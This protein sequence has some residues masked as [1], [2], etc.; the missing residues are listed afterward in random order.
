LRYRELLTYNKKC[1]EKSIKKYLLKYNNPFGGIRHSTNNDINREVTIDDL[2][3]RDA[4]QKN[5]NEDCNRSKFSFIPGTIRELLKIF[6]NREVT[7]VI[8]ARQEPE[9]VKI[10]AIVGD[11]L[12]AKTK[13]QD[14]KFIDINCICE[15]IIGSDELLNSI[16]RPD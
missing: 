9:R 10:Q 3:K 6:E 1:Y 8:E 16:I 13:E 14:I 4:N 2:P 12:V 11:I 5:I 7:I 15:I